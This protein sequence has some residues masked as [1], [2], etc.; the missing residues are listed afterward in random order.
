MCGSRYYVRSEMKKINNTGAITL[1]CGTPMLEAV[2][3]DTQS[4]IRLWMLLSERN[5]A[6][7]TGKGY[8]EGLL[9]VV[10]IK[11]HSVKRCQTPFQSQCSMRLCAQFLDPLMLVVSN[12]EEPVSSCDLS[13]RHTGNCSST[14]VLRTML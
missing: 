13:C 10:Y 3:P 12:R 5:N 14:L 6:I 9:C 8:L 2:M 11:W 1:S 7:Y 4:F